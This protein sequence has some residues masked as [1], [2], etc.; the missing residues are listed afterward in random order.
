MGSAIINDPWLKSK[1]IILF[2]KNVRPIMP[3]PGMENSFR[4]TLNLITNILSLIWMGIITDSKACTNVE[5]IPRIGCLSWM[6]AITCF[7]KAENLII[8]MSA[9]K[10][11]RKFVFCDSK[12]SDSHEMCSSCAITLTLFCNSSTVCWVLLVEGPTCPLFLFSF[13]LDFYSL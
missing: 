8:F 3:A 13:K 1:M 5:F 12:F 6:F 9:P 7:L 4:I 2:F 10:S 11:I